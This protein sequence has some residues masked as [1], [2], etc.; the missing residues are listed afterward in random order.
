MTLIR[1]PEC[2]ASISDKAQAC[3][4]CGYPVAPATPHFRRRWGWQWK[5]DTRILGL[6]LVH[7]AIGFNQKTGRPLLAKGIIAIG[8]F[9]VGLITVAQF[10][11]GL[12]GLGQ[13][14]AGG[15]VLAQFAA[16]PWFAVGQFAVAYTA[17]GQIALGKYILCQTGLGQHVW[18]PEIQDPVAVEHFTELW[19]S[20]KTFFGM[21]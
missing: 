20:V 9:A 19:G 5:S 6:P 1:C 3:P 8:W 10:G 12:L 4:H 7:I 18:S 13:F 15:L 21:P 17:I 2:G 14:I 11:V 16:S